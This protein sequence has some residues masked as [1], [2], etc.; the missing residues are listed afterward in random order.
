MMCR[1]TTGLVQALLVVAIAGC[2]SY[3]EQV[4]DIKSDLQKP[5]TANPLVD[6]K[7]VV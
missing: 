1:T 6:R 5:S 4:E 7:S 2:A 3:P